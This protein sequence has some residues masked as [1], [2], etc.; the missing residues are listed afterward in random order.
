MEIQG[1]CHPQFSK[2]EEVFSELYEENREI[3]SAFA[4]FK[5]G[6]P[7]INIWAGHQNPEKTKAWTEDTI[8]TVYSTTKGVAALC[9]A[10]AVEKGLL[11]YREKVAT[12]W[13]EFASK[14]K[15]DITVSMLLSH[16]AGICS[17]QTKNIKDYYNQKI[18][19]TKLAAMQPIWEPGTACGYHSMTFGWLVAELILRVTGK[20]IGSFFREE[21]GNKLD[22]NFFIGLPESEEDKVAKIIPFEKI[23]DGVNNKKKVKLTVAQEAQRN[24]VN[25]I[26]HHNSREWRQAEI[27]AA[28]GQG[29]AAGLAK[30]Y[31]LVTPKDP[32]LKILKD[33]TVEKMTETQIEGRDLVLAV[34]LRWGNGFVLNKH[35]IVYG[36]VEHS[37]G[38]S[39]Y[40]GS[41]VFADP[42]NKI[43][44]SYVMNKMEN[45]FA[46]D[47]RS[48]RLINAAYN[49]L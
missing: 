8:V 12:Y 6:K 47:S 31:S 4:I 33:E 3:G 25:T 44:V 21:I 10:L 27:P 16:Q 34:S 1:E 41:C 48:I 28:N 26:G 18:M 43:G 45:N 15:K 20:T 17:P 24:S 49:C 29:S 7:I 19:A 13:P 35:K 42:K 36:P 23:L 37:F 22:I 46:G 2:V 39:G 38:H 32:S 30:L 40:G 5:D 14:G 11:D 9:I